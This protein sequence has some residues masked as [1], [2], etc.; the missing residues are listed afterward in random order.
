MSVKHIV[1]DPLGKN[2][3]TLVARRGIGG[4]YCVIAECRT[5]E[6]AALIVEALNAQE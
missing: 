2:G 1:V 3:K 5:R 4:K 6:V